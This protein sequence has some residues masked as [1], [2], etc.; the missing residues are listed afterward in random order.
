MTAPF[1]SP[2]RLALLSTLAAAGI[3]FSVNSVRTLEEERSAARIC[4]AVEARDFALAL[5]LSEAPSG[6]SVAARSAAECRCDALFATQA[7]EKC[8]A[9]LEGLLGDSATGS[10][11]PRPELSVHLI[12]TWRE[13]GR[14]REAA[15][16]AK[17]AARFHP[18]EPDLFYLELV[19]R[20]GVEDEEAVLREMAG[21]V[22]EGSAA[23]ARM[24]TS[25]ANRHLQRGDSFG[26]FEA[27]ALGSSREHFAHVGSY[28]VMTPP[29][30]NLYV[31]AMDGMPSCPRQT[32]SSSV[33]RQSF[34]RDMAS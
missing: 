21:R 14:D 16:L 1:A 22:P 20:S 3:L 17:R 33:G 34:R 18:E 31:S 9:L 24:R 8:E 6:A 5:A 11:A 13:A 4:E 27:L 26:A 12:Q 10:W 2:G 29:A 28:L 7:G 23:S 19:T 32:M 30:T 25:L 15:T